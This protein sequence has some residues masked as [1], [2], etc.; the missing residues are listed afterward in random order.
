M[1]KMK[2]L[3]AGPADKAAEA[4]KGGDFKK[5]QDEIEKLAREIR[6]G[7]MDAATKEQLAKQLEQMKQKL[8]AAAQAHQSVTSL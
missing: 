3:G 2:S 7:K 6:E 8:E 4:L 5:A 1:Q